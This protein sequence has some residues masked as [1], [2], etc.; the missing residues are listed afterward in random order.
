VSRLLARWAE[1]TFWLA[2]Y[3]ERAEN[4]AR[5]LEVQ[6]V[7]ARDLRGSADWKVVL[8]I[9]ADTD[10]FLA[11]HPEGATADA[12]LRFYLVDRDNPTSILCDLRAARENARQLRPLI[13]TEL[14]THLNVFYN[15][16]AALLPAEVGE[17]RL[18]RLCAMIKEG[19]QTHAGIAAGTLYRDEAWSFAQL[20]AAIERADQ[21]TRLLDAKLL[22]FA[23]REDEEPGSA[24]DAF[25]WMAV[26]R[27][28]A[29]YQA[30]RRRHPHGLEP[31]QVATFLLCDA[32]FPRSVAANLGIVSAELERLRRRYRLRRAAEVLERVEGLTTLLEP[33]P[34]EKVMAR[35]QGLHEL[36]DSL[37]RGLATIALDLAERFFGWAPSPSAEKPAPGSAQSQTT[38]GSASG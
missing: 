25:Y 21:T 17:H 18:A 10:R 2:R 20:G 15:R 33:R 5:I 19:C 1:C 12:V 8:D 29:G 14:W 28:A 35:E 11:A 31:R 4:L 3:V 26:L 27:A 24:A 36:A 6:E 34:L 13:S 32:S 38:G 30:F 16:I 23:A 9:N 37:Q 22:A 7:F